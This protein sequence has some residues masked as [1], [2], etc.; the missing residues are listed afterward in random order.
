M[1]LNQAGFS[2]RI[3]AISADHRCMPGHGEALRVIP[4]GPIDRCR[5]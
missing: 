3:K 2:G 1:K 5:V 4:A